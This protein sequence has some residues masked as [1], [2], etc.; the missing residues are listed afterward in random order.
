VW[1]NAPDLWRWW[2]RVGNGAWASRG[3]RESEPLTLRNEIVWDKKSIAGM[4]SGD[5]T[6]YPEATE[7][8]LFFQLGRH[9]F[10]VNQTKDDYWQGWE[11]IRRFL[12]EERDK[13]G[14][15][16][17]DVKRITENHMYGHWFGTSQWVFISREHY[18]RLARAAGGRAFVRPYD[19]LLREYRTAAEV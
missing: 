14:W 3:L 1:G 8:C 10:L 19:D 17:G 16:P 4:A 9:V 11:P 5:L 7:R 6:Q 13:A 12:C 15:K 2:Y 18:E